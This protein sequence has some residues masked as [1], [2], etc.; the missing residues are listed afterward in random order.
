MVNYNNGK[1]Y[2]IQSPCGL[3]YYGSTTQKLSRRMTMH[4]YDVKRNKNLTSIPVVKAG[5]IISL[6]E[7]VPCNSKEELH[8]RERFYIDNNECV[9]KNKPR[10]KEEYLNYRKRWCEENKEHVQL[11]R[12]EYYKN[13]KEKRIAY[14]KQYYEDNKEHVKEYVK[15]YHKNNKEHVKKYVKKY[16]EK[17]KEKLKEYSKQYFENNREKHEKRYLCPCGGYYTYYSKSN[18]KKSKIHRTFIFE[19]H[20]CLNHLL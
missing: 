9:N 10:R 18:H 14:S 19:Q 5:G 3:V 17:N 6:V 7:L 15:E 16:Y 13:N 1:V 12:K 4:R 11:K 20:N 8:A 2:K